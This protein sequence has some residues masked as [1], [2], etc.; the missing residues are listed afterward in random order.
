MA[1]HPDVLMLRGSLAEKLD[2]M[3]TAESRVINAV[4]AL[5]RHIILFSTPE[6]IQIAGVRAAVADLA[7]QRA[8]WIKARDAANEIRSRLG[9]V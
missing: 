2:E 6:E 9:M 8:I 4:D 1:S 3:R 7:E 5:R